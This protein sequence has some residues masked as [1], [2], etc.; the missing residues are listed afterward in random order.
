MKGRFF[1]NIQFIK[2]TSVR[3]LFNTFKI[4]FSFIVSKT[5]KINWHWGTPLAIAIEPTTACN[6]GCPECPSGLKQFTRA[7]GNLKEEF[8]QNVIDQ[9]AKETY[10]LTF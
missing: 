7:T 1:D 6:L 9:V 2:R 5:F 10:Y 8:F 3:R 4:W